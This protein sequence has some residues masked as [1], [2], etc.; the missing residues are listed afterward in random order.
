MSLNKFYW[1]SSILPESSNNNVKEGVQLR[2]VTINETV[3]LKLKVIADP[4]R[5][6][7]R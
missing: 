6:D 2:N 7:Q 4:G 1:P 3:N 5:S